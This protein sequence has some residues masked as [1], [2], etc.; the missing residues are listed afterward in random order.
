MS[1]PESARGIRKR[2]LFDVPGDFDDTA[3][4]PSLVR[5]G[6]D[7]ELRVTYRRAGGEYL[8]VFRFEW[9]RGI[10][11]TAEPVA[12]AFQ[13]NESY[14]LLTEVENSDW[15]AGLLDGKLASHLDLN[16]FLIYI[17]DDGCYEFAAESWSYEERTF[18][19]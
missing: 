11:F 13:V 2:F 16:H 1:S 17:P 7:V 14:G 19:D 12:K 8:G 5:T 3:G 18:G 4:V 10:Q 9:A 15:I 6:P